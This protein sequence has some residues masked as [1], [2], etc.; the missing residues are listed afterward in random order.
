[1][2]SLHPIL[3]LFCLSGGAV[4]AAEAGE[5]PQFRGPTGQGISYATNVP[6]HWSATSNLVW[7]T[8]IPGRGWSSPVLADG[9]LYL[10]TAIGGAD[11]ASVSLRAL[12][13]NA[14]DGAIL[15]NIEVLQPEPS[16]AKKIHQKNSP[17]SPTPILDHGRLYVHFGHMGTAALDFSGKILWRQ[18]ALKYSPL[19]GNGGSPALMDDLLVFSCDGTKDPFIVAL[20]AGTGDL[21]W[22]T[23]RNSDAERKFSFSTPLVIEVGG[24]P[25]G[26]TRAT[27]TGGSDASIPRGERQ[28]ISP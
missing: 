2:K 4:S 10:T 23:P 12:C 18:T 25:R 14:I 20:D 21:R 8:G 19:H 17:A 6:L 11:A 3:F 9:R 5:W 27:A 13:V 16:S 22:K 15:W 26:I 1:M 28:I 24:A 7:K